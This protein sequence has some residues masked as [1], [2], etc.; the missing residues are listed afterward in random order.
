MQLTD[1][2]SMLCVFKDNGLEIGGFRLRR[3]MIDRIES[4]T[5]ENHKGDGRERKKDFHMFG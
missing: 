3:Q 5:A 1:I 4:L 2:L